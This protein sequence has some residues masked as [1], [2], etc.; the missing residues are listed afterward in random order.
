MIFILRRKEKQVWRGKWLVCTEKQGPVGGLRCQKK[1]SNWYGLFAFGLSQICV[2]NA[3]ASAYPFPY[4]AAAAATSLNEWMRPLLGVSEFWILNHNN[5]RWNGVVGGW[6]DGRFKSSSRRRY[7]YDWKAS[8]SRRTETCRARI[9]IL[10]G[11]FFFLILV[12]FCVLINFFPKKKKRN[13][14]CFLVL[15]NGSRNGGFRVVY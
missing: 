3:G 8:D 14:P 9:K 15:K 5:G 2:L 1:E 6:T 13:L 4:D 11:F 10:G 12:L 7:R